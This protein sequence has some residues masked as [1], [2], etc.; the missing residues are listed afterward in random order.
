MHA[1]ARCG[2]EE[3]RGARPVAE[4]PALQKGA[5]ASLGAENLLTVRARARARGWDLGLGW[6][7][8][9]GVGVGAGV[10]VS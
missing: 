2:R 8:R 9:V 3:H 1:A 5:L 6:G 7:G 4:L 10:V